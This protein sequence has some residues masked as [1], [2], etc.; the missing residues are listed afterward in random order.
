[1]R[2]FTRGLVVSWLL[3]L[4]VIV[5]KERQHIIMYIRYHLYSVTAMQLCETSEL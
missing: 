5:L 1:M 2:R 4:I 3:M